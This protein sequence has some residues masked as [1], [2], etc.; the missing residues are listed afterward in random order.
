MSTTETQAPARQAPA[1]PTPEIAKAQAETAVAELQIVLSQQ[2]D[3]K[4]STVKVWV[5]KVMPERG[6]LS[7]GIALGKELGCSPF[8][9]CAANQI[10]SQAEAFLFERLPWL[11][12][13]VAEAAASETPGAGLLQLKLK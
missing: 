1:A 5:A 4:V 8:C 2:P 12:R 9:G 11:T 7:L 10:A 6:M 3:P 13:V